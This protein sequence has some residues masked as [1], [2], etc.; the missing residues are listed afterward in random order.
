MESHK[1]EFLREKIKPLKVDNNTNVDELLQKL[2]FYKN[3][4]QK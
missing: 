2:T 1:N 3:I 4:M